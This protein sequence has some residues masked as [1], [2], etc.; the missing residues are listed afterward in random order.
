MKNSKNY[1]KELLILIVIFV[2]SSA[3]FN[4]IM[5]PYGIFNS[6]E[7]EKINQL[8]PEFFTHLRLAKAWAVYKHKPDGIIL[9][10]SRSEFGLDPNHSEWNTQSVYNLGL[11]GANMYEV[12]RYFQHA[13]TI[14]PQKQ[15]ILGVDFFMFNIFA[16]NHADFDESNLAMNPKFYSANKLFTLISIDT[17]W[18]SIKTLLKQTEVKF[19]YLSNGQLH[20]TNYIRTVRKQGG[21]TQFFLLTEEEHMNNTWLNKPRKQYS[22]VHPKTGESTLKYFCR[23]LEIAY[24][25]DVDLRLLI[26]PSHARLWEALYSVGL[27]PQFEQW[28]REM[29][30]INAEQ[31]NKYGKTPFPLWD[32]SGYNSFTTEKVPLLGDTNTEMKWYWE[33]SHYNKILGDLVLYRIFGEHTTANDFGKLLESKNIEQQLAKIRIEQQDYRVSVDH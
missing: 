7:I 8:K 30:R 19:S 28:K 27:W 32:F 4:W 21:H 14:K 11:S 1:I 10:S 24:R 25:D 29:V 20:W 17:I 23:F 9:G 26:S 33:A 18:S 31:A 13:H 12:L 16:S 15:V 2:I 3:S 22:F 6:P 5:N